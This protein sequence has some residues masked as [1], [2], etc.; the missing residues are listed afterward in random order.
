MK[1]RDTVATRRVPNLSIAA[2][3]LP[4]ADKVLG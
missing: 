2:S 1:G 4:D 3:S